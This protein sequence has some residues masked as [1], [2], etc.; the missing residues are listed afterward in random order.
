MKK[1]LLVVCIIFFSVLQSFTQ[2]IGSDSELPV[3]VPQSP[4]AYA[5][6][7]YGEVDVNESTGSI[8][9]SIP[10]YTYQAG[11]ISVPISLAYSGNGV[12]VDQQPTTT[13]IN[14]SLIAGGA[15]T[16]QV[17]D[18]P[19]ELAYNPSPLLNN[20]KFYSNYDTGSSEVIILKD[21]QGAKLIPPPL[22][23]FPN[24][25]SE[26]VNVIRNL[27][28]DW[29][30]SEVDI[31]NYNFMGNSGSF[32]IDENWEPRLIKYDKE[33]SIDI[34][35]I[36]TYEYPL[37]TT[38][39][40]ITTS[41]GVQYI[42]GGDDAYEN[43]NSGAEYTSS[44]YGTAGSTTESVLSSFYITQIIHPNGDVVNFQYDYTSQYVY[45]TGKS[46]SISVQ[47]G[48]VCQGPPSVL[49]YSSNTNKTY[50]ITNHKRL[51]SKITSN[52]SDEAI[53]FNRID[54]NDFKKILNEVIVKDGTTVIKK[55]KLDYLYPTNLTN[56]KDKFFLE[57]VDE[58]NSTGQSF[59][60]KYTMAY[61][62][63][64]SLPE[65]TRISTNTFPQDHYG[66]YNGKPNLNFAP[67][68]INSLIDGYFGNLADK[69]PVFQFAKRGSLSSI[70]Y[71]TGGST[72]FE[73]ESGKDLTQPIASVTEVQ[74]LRLYYNFDNYNDELYDEI[75]IAP[76]LNQNGGTDIPVTQTIS[77]LYTINTEGDIGHNNWV[78]IIV[79]EQNS[80]NIIEE[81]S[82]HIEN[83]EDTPK[84]YEG[85][86]VFDIVEGT[87]YE[88]ILKF[89]YIGANEIDG[90][91]P[92]TI[93]NSH[94]IVA[95]LR[96]EYALNTP[97]TYA[98]ALGIR[99]KSI[100]NK[101][102]ND[103]IANY[104]RYYYNTKERIS[105]KNNEYST[106]ENPEKIFFPKYYSINGGEVVCPSEGSGYDIAYLEKFTVRSSSLTSLFID[107]SSKKM[108][109]IIT[110]SYG[111]DN[112]E[113]GGKE[114]KFILE[115]DRGAYNYMGRQ[116]Y[117]PN[118]ANAS[119]ENGTKTEE[120]LFEKTNGSFNIQKETFYTYKDTKYDTLISSKVINTI[121]QQDFELVVNTEQRVDHINIGFYETYSRW[122]G[123][124]SI[125]TKEYFEN[126]I[127]TTTQA[128]DYQGNL[129]GLP[130]HEITIGSDGKSIL[131]RTYYPDEISS[132]S[133]LGPNLLSSS[134]LALI[135]LLK[136]DAQYRIATPIQVEIYSD[137]DSDDVYQSNELLNTQ[138]T[139]YK[140][141]DGHIQPEFIQ[142]QK[143]EYVI[144]TNQL[145]NRIVYHDYDSNG[146]PLEISKADG[147]H[148][149]Y[150]WGYNN[151]FPIAKI[152]NSSF[153]G[154]PFPGLQTAINTAITSS[155]ADND[156]T[157]GTLGNEGTLRT[158]LNVIRNLLPN[159]MVT[160]YTYDPLIGV[161][162]ITDPRERT[163]YYHY[164]DFN[165]LLYVKDHDGYIL[166]ENEYK[167]RP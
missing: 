25:N 89:T 19:D 82:I 119:W 39:I 45:M 139:V 41:D 38:K 146:N 92:N 8:S 32:Y 70:T 117:S 161:T 96:Y 124:E 109:P 163:I 9:P 14:W 118:R 49:Y 93:D 86:I 30:D 57:S 63:I 71:P 103:S 2:G 133:S 58:Q 100:T 31:F 42:F 110:V 78:R 102:G 69:E 158:D 66:Y 120:T 134:E 155:D 113:N 64:E 80:S 33:I 153:Q 20:R 77:A 48:G 36:H 84:L 121:V 108:Y 15:I 3:L 74:V 4:E 43:I 148:I 114:I 85:T 160:T 159:A 73:Y 144:N 105:F 129:A 164:D 56:Q 167:Y 152:E 47:Q 68:G 147:T 18:R 5:L 131:K 52:R 29:I 28:E 107:D 151:L 23:P 61:D 37:T 91:N 128:F 21:L 101:L 75:N 130:T 87:N 142:T 24:N 60:K 11:N 104:K 123:I 81:K 150:I 95:F 22:G 76:S 135:D 65:I 6:G 13:G 53:E 67:R 50:S 1:F 16:R 35:D 83:P 157:H 40:T 94:E 17:R 55:F 62:A 44:H 7:K 145:E 136:E 88:V 132:T 166:G 46:Q 122:H 125:V 115:R 27:N 138:R 106:I 116:I 26:W 34:S 98:E 156:R 12:K 97:P 10:L 140:L 154:D 51:L 141:D 112:F 99:I 149:V 59:G 143:G 72:H 79:K 54:F 165:R 90:L 162:S 126:D 111:G 127:V 137:I